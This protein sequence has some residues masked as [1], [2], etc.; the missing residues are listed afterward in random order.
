MFE[1]MSRGMNLYYRGYLI[2][3]EIRSIY[4]T[5]YGTRPERREL[6]SAGTSRR[7]MEWVD[8][9]V[10]EQRRPSPMVWPNWF[11]RTPLSAVSRL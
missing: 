11:A 2:H 4:Y 10:A 9:R 3:E 8:G 1:T 5:I 7:A 6:A